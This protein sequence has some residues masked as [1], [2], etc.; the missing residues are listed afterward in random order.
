M[1]QIETLERRE[2]L[3]ANVKDPV[4]VDVELS[5]WSIDER[6]RMSAKIHER[7]KEKDSCLVDVVL[8]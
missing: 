5:R 4:H 8:R 6:G 1:T 2:N 3:S 7:K